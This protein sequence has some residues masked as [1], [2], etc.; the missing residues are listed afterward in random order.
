MADDV[1]QV[2]GRPG[3]GELLK[4]DMA[5]AAEGRGRRRDLRPLSR[6]MPF[7]IA[8]RGDA[9]LAAAFLLASTSASLGLTWAGRLLTDK[10]FASG[11]SGQ[12]GLWF[13]IAAAVVAVLA[14]TT[15]G[16]F[17]FITKLG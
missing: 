6:L 3:A 9:F 10:G 16:R 15:A 13:L 4:A 2:A 14:G 1:A 7:V 12:L 5:S 8:H 17:F 11:Q